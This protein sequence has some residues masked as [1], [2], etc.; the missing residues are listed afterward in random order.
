MSLK[1]HNTRAAKLEPSQVL[2]IR[3]KYAA[4]WT[5]ARL[6]RHFGVSVIQIGRIVRG[7][8]WQHLSMVETQS[9]RRMEEALSHMELPSFPKEEVEASQARLLARLAEDVSK[10]R[11]SDPEGLINKLKGD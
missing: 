3:E 11:S 10:E 8:S 7:E 2:E 5:Q 9:D 4:D 1:R 6:S